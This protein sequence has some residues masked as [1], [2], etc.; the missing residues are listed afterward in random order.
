MENLKINPD[1]EIERKQ[2]SFNIEE[3]AIWWNGG[4]EKLNDKRLRDSHF[5][6]DPD[7]V[8][9]IP[10]S[11]LSHKDVY[12]N[13]VEK[14]TKIVKKLQQLSFNK[15][16]PEM[17]WDLIF[18]FR[19][20]FGSLI[21]SSL[22]PD[23]NPLGLHYSMFVP[24]IF[25]QA[26][27]EQQNEWLEKAIK[28]QIVGTYAQTELGHG[29]FLRGLETI[30]DYDSK[31][32]EFILNSPKLTSYKWWPGGLGHT[33]NFAIVMA[34]LHINGKEY[35]IHPFIVQLR[36]LETHMPLKG[37]EVGEIGSKLYM[38]ATN[39]GYLGLKNVRIP[40]KNMLMRNA[41]VLPCG[42]FE[43]KS[44]SVLTYG[45]MQFVR[46]IILQDSTNIL[47]RAVTIATRYSCVRRQSPINTNSPEPKIMEHVTQ[48]LKIFPQIAKTI[49]FKVTANSIYDLFSSVRDE[50][51]SGNLKR[52][53]ELHALSC[54]MKAIYSSETA[55]GV[56]ILRLACGGHG[57]MNS[58]NFPNLY[59]FATAACT[60]EGEN[61]V[62]YLQTAR[63]LIK[64]WPT[65]YM[66]RKLDSIIAYMGVFVNN[67]P[68]KL[69]GSVASIIRAFQCTTTQRVR[70]AYT[71]LNR[72]KK[73]GSTTEEANNLS[74]IELTQIAELFGRTYI[75]QTSYLAIQDIIN[76]VSSELGIVFEQLMELYAIT[77]FLAYLGDIMRF[78]SVNGKQ[79]DD[80]H[81]RLENLL[82]KIRRNAVGIVDGFDIHDGL[83]NSALG[84]YDGNV[85]ERI[86]ME[87]KKSPLNK[88]PVNRSF[89]LHLKPFLKSNL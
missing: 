14:V 80:L 75:L 10:S 48:Q 59:G 19:S 55:K 33:A 84:A 45:T 72:R 2:C 73:L 31:T 69:D 44:S 26:T 53:P 13:S 30:A 41:Q 24:T 88:E 77:E 16:N 66:R 60:Y 38:N 12:E 25:G 74:G 46:V 43:R 63:Y 67:P 27:E 52:L 11:Y 85:Y 3:M 32:E 34:Q 5:F 29:T 83:L 89:H 28:F 1:L 62:M 57:Y 22:L 6:S 87:A 81:T 86:F 49:I 78:V 64:S 58:S 40:R 68:I 36:D 70:L 21:G 39:N 61:T 15:D 18:T 23:H 42:K 17:T 50:L 4:K 35:G 7:L 37:I 51:N 54:C 56:E 47:A 8:N 79:I 71:R 82:K 65:I 9:T 20:M 76:S